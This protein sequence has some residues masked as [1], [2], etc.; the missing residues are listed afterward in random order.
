MWAV[1][2]VGVPKVLLV[3][4]PGCG[5]TTVCGLIVRD[6]SSSHDIL[7][8]TTNDRCDTDKDAKQL[9]KNFVANRTIESFF[10]SKPKMLLIE[11][12]DTLVEADRGY[13]SFLV[14][15]VLDPST[16]V[17]MTCSNN[18][19]R[20]VM[21][22][23]KRTTHT[24]V[25][26]NPSVEEVCTAMQA[27]FLETGY[28]F[29]TD[30]LTRVARI[31]DG[32]VRDVVNNMQSTDDLAV[33]EREREN[34]TLAQSCALECA[35]RVLDNYTSVK[36]M[37]HISD[38]TVCNVLYENYVRDMCCNRRKIPV[39]DCLNVV[40]SV[41]DTWIGC[42]AMEARADAHEHVLTLR[43]GCITKQ[44]CNMTR[45][46]PSRQQRVYT[47]P[48]AHP[49]SHL[50]KRLQAFGEEIGLHDGRVLL[51]ALDIQGHGLLT[52]GGE[53]H[54]RDMIN[55]LCH[56]M[57]CMHA[58]PTKTINKIKRVRRNCELSSNG[59]CE[60]DER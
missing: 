30:R 39:G 38:N 10:A 51:R 53:Q 35:H 41:I 2:S 34:T 20:R 36:D 37:Y 18:H 26:K 17:L 19:N 9:V 46:A 57:G 40:K 3:G 58:I 55:M 25:M 14:S 21:D 23:E 7:H 45:K 28:A 32:N 56:Y 12:I 27:W 44:L 49:R 1:L 54:P 50:G 59:E 6:F 24:F 4:P 60:E 42:S 52:S 22:V 8:H 31:H 29:D 5:K 43:V 47:R 16:V 15:L 13:A 11:D 48:V 33:M